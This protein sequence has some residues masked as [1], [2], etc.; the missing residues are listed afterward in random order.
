MHFVKKSA[1]FLQ[2]YLKKYCKFKNKN[3]LCI[4]RTTN[5]NKTTQHYDTRKIYKGR[6]NL[7]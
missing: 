2:F 1:F 7:L 3:Y 4:V 6:K 5:N